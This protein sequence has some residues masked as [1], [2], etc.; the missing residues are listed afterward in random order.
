MTSHSRTANP[1]GASA[2]QSFRRLKM[3][4]ITNHA[5]WRS[6]NYHSFIAPHSTAVV[7]EEQEISACAAKMDPGPHQANE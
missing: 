7:I 2:D 6:F 3:S 1:E 4:P 5:A